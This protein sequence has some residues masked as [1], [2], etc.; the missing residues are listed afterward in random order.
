MAKKA[1]WTRV[2]GNRYAPRKRQR[3]L[4]MERRLDN[5]GFGDKDGRYPIFEPVV[6]TIPLAYNNFQIM[7]YEFVVAANIFDILLQ[8]PGFEIWDIHRITAF[9]DDA[10]A[11]FIRLRLLDGAGPVPL[12]M[13]ISPDEGF[14]VPN[15]EDSS[16]YPWFH[17]IA[18]AH[19]DTMTFG[20]LRATNDLVPHVES[21]EIFTN[22][23]QIIVYVLRERLR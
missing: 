17:H 20:P 19:S 12:I 6:R 3:P 15:N 23:T 8:P 13:E 21:G 9:H 1:F 5:Q 16:I 4:F 22:G 2:L 7:V 11:R 18:P 10:A 14:D